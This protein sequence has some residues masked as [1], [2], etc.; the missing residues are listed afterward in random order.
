MPST[1]EQHR[2]YPRRTTAV[3]FSTRHT[4]HHVRTRAG[5]HECIHGHTMRITNGGGSR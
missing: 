1:L 5:W 3:I 2:R 4:C